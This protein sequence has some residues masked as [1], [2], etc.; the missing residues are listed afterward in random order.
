MTRNL[1]LTR[2]SQHKYHIRDRNRDAHDPAS[3]EWGGVDQGDAIGQEARG[4]HGSVADDAQQ[5]GDIDVL[6]LGWGQR[7]REILLRCVIS[8]YRCILLLI[9]IVV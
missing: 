7:T 5:A 6:M 1:S 9:L 8:I 2:Y 3:T 4:E